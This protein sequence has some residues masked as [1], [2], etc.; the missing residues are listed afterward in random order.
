MIVPVILNI[1]FNKKNLA[2]KIYNI[3]DNLDNNI[4]LNIYYDYKFKII[5]TN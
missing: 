4:K 2:T 3:C 1:M 5:K